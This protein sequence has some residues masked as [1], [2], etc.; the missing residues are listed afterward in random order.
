[1]SSVRSE[2]NPDN[3][4][5]R[6][7]HYNRIELRDDEKMFHSNFESW[8]NTFRQLLLSCLRSFD[9]CDWTRPFEV[10]VEKTEEQ[11]NI[12]IDWCLRR[13]RSISSKICSYLLVDLAAQRRAENGREETSFLVEDEDQEDY[14]SLFLMFVSSSL[15]RILSPHENITSTK[16]RFLFNL[17]SILEMFDIGT[18]IVFLC[19]RRRR[20][21]FRESSKIDRPWT[22]NFL[23][24][25]DWKES[26]ER[27]VQ[28]NWTWS[29]RE[30]NLVVQTI[31]D[32]NL[33]SSVRLKP[34]SNH[35]GDWLQIT[36]TG[37]IRLFTA[38]KRCLNG[39]K[40]VDTH[41]IRAVY[42][43]KPDRWITTVF[44]PF[45]LRCLYGKI[46]ETVFSRIH[47]VPAP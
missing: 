12:L 6:W 25:A 37:R 41:R 3:L 1:M 4:T 7:T 2:E 28:L 10:V 13:I 15:R 31:V 23:F 35:P 44:K 27:I 21:V 14:L 40:R 11:L 30:K 36:D 32:M 24:S 22:T 39:R 43:R 18:L 47:P 33:P 45:R 16:K 19:S 46:K 5:H 26:H 42:C 8:T 38:K 17:L 20:A 9:R 29:F 34:M